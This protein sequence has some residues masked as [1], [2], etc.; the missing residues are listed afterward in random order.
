MLRKQ[1]VIGVAFF[2]GLTSLALIAGEGLV[3]LAYRNVTTS[4]TA[5][6]YF[7][8]RW[9]REHLQRNESGFREREGG[10]RSDGDPYRIAVVGDS[11][12]FGPGIAVEERFSDRLR[13]DLDASGGAFD[14][15]QFAHPGAELDG[16]L[17]TLTLSVL[18]AEP[19]FVLLQWS[20][21]DIALPRIGIPRLR[22]LLANVEIALWLRHHSA[23]YDVANR[24]WQ[25][26]QLRGT[27][28]TEY[29]RFIRG[30]YGDR[31]GLGWR[32]AMRYLDRFIERCEGQG[33]E[34][35]IVLFPVL[36]RSLG[37]DYAFAFLHDQML[38]ECQER[39]IP[40]LDL[41]PT[42]GPFSDRM[43]ELWVNDFDHHPGSRAHRLAADRIAE[44]F[45]F[46]GRADSG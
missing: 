16:H 27:W 41:R 1:L 30:R 28:L 4:S 39:R 15:L 21:N 12:T 18:A 14:V 42:F 17:D 34:M 35:G 2:L 7:S 44:F 25:A 5:E 24:R 43:E 32:T 20:T 26:L 11:V 13:L 3:R 22:P 6:G 46:P 31:N 33:I 37:D 40:C 8:R 23:L 38:L 10:F 19:D 29:V 9:K 45:D 36:T